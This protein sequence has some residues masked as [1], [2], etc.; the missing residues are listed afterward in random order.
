MLNTGGQAASGT[1][2][3][4]I[5]SGTQDIGTGIASGTRERTSIV[6]R[7]NAMRMVEHASMSS[8][9]MLEQLVRSKMR[10]G[11]S[12]LLRTLRG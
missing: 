11:L 6:V 8:Q 2:D 10:K 12:I 7:G 4:G 3:F 5:A 9:A 1:Q